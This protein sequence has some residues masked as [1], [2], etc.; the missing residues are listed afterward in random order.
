MISYY[1]T[2]FLI[3]IKLLILIY[4]ADNKNIADFA[5]CYWLW[6]KLIYLIYK[7]KPNIF[8]I[9]GKYNSDLKFEYLC[10]IKQMLCYLKKIMYLEI[11]WRANPTKY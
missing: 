5:I 10:I 8:F 1:I 2:I 4:W 11:M 6:E 3:K 7:F 9:I